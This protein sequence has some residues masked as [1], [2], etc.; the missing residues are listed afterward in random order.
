MIHRF[1]WIPACAGVTEA[2]RH[3]PR[4]GRFRRPRRRGRL[5]WKLAWRR[6]LFAALVLAHAPAALA[7]NEYD[8]PLVTPASNLQQ[9]GFVRIIN[10]SARTGTV[11]VHAIDDRGERFGPADLELDANESVQFNSGDL[12]RGNAR[13]GLSPGVG[14]GTGNWRLELSTDLDIE[15][16]AYIRTSDGFLTDMHDVAVGEE[17]ATPDGRSMR[18][19]VPIFNPGS[20]LSLQSRLR[21]VNRGERAADIVITALDARG[22]P[23]PE[24]EVSLNLP[25]GAARMLSA[26]QLEEGDA[27]LTGRFGKG[28]GKWQLTVTSPTPVQ[29]MNLMQTRSGHLANLSTSPWG[30]GLE[31]DAGPT[32]GSASLADWTYAEGVAIAPLDLPAATGGTDPLTYALTP[33]VPG[34][35]FDAGTRRL[36]GTPTRAGTWRMTY[37]VTDADGYRDARIFT[38]TVAGVLAPLDQAGFETLAAGK[39]VALEFASGTRVVYRFMSGGRFEATHFL[40]F[41]GIPITVGYGG[42]YTY[43]RT[44]AGTATLA[45]AYEGLLSGSTC[46]VAVVFD[47]TTRGTFSSSCSTPEVLGGRGT[48]TLEQ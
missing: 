10:R 3:A 48:W 6:G 7:Q 40:D 47:A 45:V 42:S 31:P 36:T 23:P 8:L 21:L 9:Q 11:R 35:R 15:P 30:G 32:F 41:E 1:S 27:E 46:D 19:R 34:L 17:V 33:G 12:E 39:R 22:N 29:V 4:A 13:V 2:L 16:L 28:Q 20:N 25:A 38:L 24:G 44:G 43:A 14:E 5:R 37:R 18:Y 26:Q